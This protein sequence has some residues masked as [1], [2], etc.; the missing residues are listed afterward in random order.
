MWKKVK[1]LMKI[2]PLTMCCRELGR[3]IV[4]YSPLGYGFFADCKLT[5][6]QEGDMRGVC[7]CDSLLDLFTTLL[8]GYI[9][10]LLIGILFSNCFSCFQHPYCAELL[11]RCF[12]VV[13][14]GKPNLELI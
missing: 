9:S 13:K 1:V 2:V 10:L 8:L 11:D 3:A 6:A 4:P 12:S 7:V 5:D 14:E